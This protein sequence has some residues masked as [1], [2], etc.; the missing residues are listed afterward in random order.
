MKLPT[1]RR[2]AAR[3]RHGVALVLFVLLVFVFLAIATVVI[4]IGRAY[5]TQNQMQVAVD[6]A[7][8][9]GVRLR[10]AD[11]YQTLSNTARRPRV[12]NLVRKVFDDDLAPTLPTAGL[13]GGPTIPGD[14]AD[15]MNFGAGPIFSIQGGTGPLNAQGVIQVPVVPFWDDPI[16][17]DNGGN[18]TGSQAP[19]Q[20]HGDQ[21]SGTYFADLGH[22]ETALY[23]RADFRHGLAA[24]YYAGLSYLVRMR[25][26]G[27]TNALDNVNGVSMSGPTIPFLFGLGS[28]M[29]AS[30]GTGYDP[31]RD[32]LSV[33]A[34][35]IASGVPALRASPRP[36]NADG[37]PIIGE[38]LIGPGPMLGLHPVVISYDFWTQTLTSGFWPHPTADSLEIVSS[39]GE[40][41]ELTT[42]Q[43][44]GR[45]AQ[46]A[47]CIGQEIVPS[48]PVA[49]P[50]GLLKAG[51]VAIQAP[52][53]EP[54][55]S[56][57]WRVIGYGFVDAFV[58]PATGRLSV[59]A[60]IKNQQASETSGVTCW[61]A[62]NGASARLDSTA[63]Q[64][65]ATQWSAVFARN[66]ALAFGP[67]SNT[68]NGNP[69]GEPSNDYR[70]IRPGTL[71]APVLVR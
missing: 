56:L 37:T 32:G 4:D 49:M 59:S 46:Y 48:A 2:H 60:G 36:L 13:L 1:H 7:A 68:Q 39:T 9:E 16:L 31:R 27:T 30:S 5:V 10:D 35:A 66:R 51:Y 11:A 43:V 21:V 50:D 19:N 40:L 61:V 12:S 25:R 64:L 47:T 52:I 20:A 55:G 6:T 18:A 23:E 33:R 62:P 57:R 8:L 34:T 38:G 63:P 58:I 44:V 22:E 45:F 29:M 53:A 65:D 3:D 14:D 41:R 54:D 24:E 70:R 28:L 42:N 26:T 71:L 17:Q 15:A 67:W 69:T